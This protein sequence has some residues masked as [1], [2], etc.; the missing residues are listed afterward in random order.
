MS[1]ILLEPSLVELLTPAA[2]RALE[3]AA[4]SLA[5]TEQDEVNL[6]HLLAGLLAEPE[7]QAAQVLECYGINSQRVEARWPQVRVQGG[8]A[9]GSGDK[10]GPA[11]DLLAALRVAQ[12]YCQPAMIPESLASQHLLLGLFSVAGEV[13]DWMAE[14]GCD[15]AE[16]V[17]RLE[18]IGKPVG[19]PLDENS[20]ALAAPGEPMAAMDQAADRAE[21][22]VSPEV[23]TPRCA[24][25]DHALLRIVDAAANRTSEA[26]RTLEDVTRFGLNDSYLT[27][28]WKRLRH[29]L[30]VAVSVFA[31]QD[32]LAARDVAGDVGTQ[33]TAASERVRVDLEHVLR[34]ANKRLQEG[35]RTLEELCKLTAPET[36]PRIEAMRYAAYR[37]ESALAAT[38]QGQH[39]LA[40]AR[41]YVLI[42]GAVD[43]ATFV[44][45]A[46][47]LIHAGVDVIQLRDKQ[48]DDRQLLERA[49]TLRSLT[50]GTR[51]LFIMNDRADLAL[52]S[53][54]DGVHVGQE[55][56]SVRDVRTIVGPQMLVGVSTHSL[57][58]AEQAVVQGAN[59]IGVGPTFPSG[60][61]SF[62]SYPGL[63]F[64]CAVAGRVS[65]PAFAIGGITRD[66]LPEVLKTG[67]QRVAV[68]SGITAASDMATAAEAIK[69]ELVARFP[70]K[71][72]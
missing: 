42:D 19:E 4:R 33:I 35:L 68:S 37:L 66:N 3:A 25:P 17:A 18:Q 62:D 47:R 30:Q 45:R 72:I 10:L 7:C 54:A 59:Y 51:T 70:R 21:C 40:D 14:Q 34:A 28:H 6:P 20:N 15:V 16:A 29:D 49:R 55:E 48:L 50:R 11:P 13:T 57:E 27:E 44:E 39:R 31:A 36:A 2:S 52:V 63:E 58:Q 53:D 9:N 56:L 43:L 46:T 71:G 22:V 32:L 41:L 38:R 26:I 5:A 60:T 64:L 23:N 12:R 67:I 69:A 1:R 8:Q 61:K 65:L 24:L